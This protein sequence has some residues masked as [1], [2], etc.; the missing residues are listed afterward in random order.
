MKSSTHPGSIT[1]KVG[2][3]WPSLLANEIPWRMRTRLRLSSVYG[4]GNATISCG[5]LKTVGGSSSYFDL[6]SSYFKPNSGVGVKATVTGDWIYPSA[7]LVSTADKIEAMTNPMFKLYDNFNDDFDQN[8]Y[9]VYF[10]LEATLL[11]VV[12][13]PAIATVTNSTHVTVAWIPTLD[14]DKFSQTGWEVKIFDNATKIAGGFNSLTTTPLDSYVAYDASNS[15]TNIANLPSGTYWAYVRIAKNVNGIQIWSNP[16]SVSFI[17]NTT[18]NPAPTIAAVYAS[19]GNTSTVT[20]TGHVT[21]SFTNHTVTLEK[22][23]DG[24]VSWRQVGTDAVMD[25]TTQIL[26]WVDYE[27]KIGVVT[28]YRVKQHSLSATLYNIDSTMSSVVTVTSIANFSW[29][30]R[31]LTNPSLYFSNDVP[32]ETGFTEFVD[33]QLG[34]FRTLDGDK[35]TVVSSG[36][37]GL[38]GSFTVTISDAA[39]WA[40]FKTLLLQTDVFIFTDPYGWVKHI[41]LVGR[42]MSVLNTMSAPIHKIVITYVEV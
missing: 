25:Q 20:V 24:G 33:E 7:P 14:A 3:L 6:G 19:T 31:S 21:G 41:K 9:E 1:Y 23:D 12:T 27:L 13:V 29:M 40:L 35:P 16:V 36:I 37:Y 15:W 17:M 34:I 42:D 22:S 26:V 38:P 8:F 10:D 32:I 4:N 11:P 18:P 28:S 2:S 5:Y 39:Q 30:L